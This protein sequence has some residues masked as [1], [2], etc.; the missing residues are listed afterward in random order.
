[1]N[2]IYNSPYEILRLQ[3][4]EDPADPNAEQAQKR[5]DLDCPEPE[6]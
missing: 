4:L 2:G 6:K 5:V 1:M 3:G